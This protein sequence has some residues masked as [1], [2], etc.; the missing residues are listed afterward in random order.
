[1]IISEECLIC[2]EEISK[3]QRER[4]FANFTSLRSKIAFQV[5]K[6]IASCD[7]HGLYSCVQLALCVTI[8][9]RLFLFE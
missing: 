9:K 4:I 1:M 2:E 5:A 6:K 7:M 8:S 3:L